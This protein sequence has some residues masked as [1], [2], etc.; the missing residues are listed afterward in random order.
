VDGVGQ[1]GG[2]AD[3]EGRLSGRAAVAAALAALALPATAGSS[4]PPGDH[5]WGERLENAKRFAAARTGKVSIGV[6]DPDGS[7][8]G[9]RANRQYNSASTVKVML[10][11]AYLRH[12]DNN[13]EPLT[14]ADKKLLGPMIK[15]SDNKAAT[16]IRD[17]VGNDALVR[18]A[19]RSGMERFEPAASWPASQITARDQAVWMYGIR[20]EIPGRHRR[21]AM[22]LLS[23]IIPRQSW[24]IPREAPSGWTV[25]FKG[26]WAPSGNPGWTVNQVSQLRREHERFAITVLTRQGPSQGYG[27]ETIR[28]VAERLLKDFGPDEK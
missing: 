24:G 23:S 12:G 13:N 18:V 14:S 10:M 21:Y 15:R 22:D 6:I 28:G 26:G 9:Y 11:V 27:R 17:I 8:H 2:R 1:P 25:Y 3:R 20:R 19:K 5:P 7:F 4:A 16:T